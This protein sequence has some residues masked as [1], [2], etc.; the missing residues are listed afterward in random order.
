MIEIILKEN[1][2][3]EPDGYFDI[4]SPVENLDKEFRFTYPDEY[5]EYNKYIICCHQ[6]GKTFLL[7]IN[8]DKFVVSTV[9]TSLKG[10]W[11]LY[12]VFSLNEVVITEGQV[13]LSTLENVHTKVWHEIVARVYNTEYD[14]EGIQSFEEDENV[15]IFYDK[16]V[17]MINNGG[18]SGGVSSWN[19]LEDKPFGDETFEKVIL[20]ESNFLIPYNLY[21]DF[22]IE[23]F[24]TDLTE[25]PLV[26]GEKYIVTFNGVEQ[27]AVCVSTL[28]GTEK[29]YMFPILCEEEG[30][31]EPLEYDGKIFNV[32][33]GY[34]VKGDS[35][36]LMIQVEHDSNS[37]IPVTLGIKQIQG[38]VKQLDEKYIPNTIAR[39]EDIPTGSV[40]EEDVANAIKNYM[41]ENPVSGG[42]SV[43]YNEEKEAIVFSGSTGGES[44]SGGSSCDF[45]EIGLTDEPAQIEVFSGKSYKKVELNMSAKATT[46]E[47]MV[48]TFNDK[49][50]SVPSIPN[51]YYIP[52]TFSVFV[53]EWVSANVQNA[54]YILNNASNLTANINHSSIESLKLTMTTATNTFAKGCYITV[55]GYK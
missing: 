14:A 49:A 44:G 51:T 33:V 52:I 36:S 54:H 45:Y 55:I 21:Q 22:H 41:E 43:T 40:S 13:D 27:E 30:Y 42:M 47:A 24:P 18:T 26:D 2:R 38:N 11:Y 48:I 39:V 5:K 23:S 31:G 35:V 50:V 53:R 6:T 46:S 15:K 25:S 12:P 37:D 28:N 8:D 1:G 4:G 7:P 34:V 10:L 17:A 32:A 20:G 9:L 29:Q 3:I 19:D 16:I